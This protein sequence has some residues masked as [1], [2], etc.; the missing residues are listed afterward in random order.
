MGVISMRFRLQMA[1]LLG[2]AGLLAGIGALAQDAPPVSEL[3]QSVNQGHA[4]EALKK[5]AALRTQS[6]TLK[7]LSRVEGLA[8]F[9][10]GDL[11][12]ADEAFRMAIQEDPTDLEAVQMRGL[13]LFRRGRPADAIPLLEASKAKRDGKA[14][15]YYVLGLC[16]MDARRYDDSRHA[17]AAQYGFEPDSAPAYLVAARMMLRRESLP[18]A[19]QYAEK[20]LALEPT[21]PLAHE[22]LGEIA[23]AGNHLEEAITDFEAEKAHN[24]LEA[25]VYDRLGDAYVRAAKY[26]DAQLSLQQAVLLEPTATGPYILL[27]K[28]LLKKGDPLAAATYLERANGLDPANYMTHSLLAQAYR[29][30]GRKDDAT[31]ENEAAQKIQSASEP[32]FSDVK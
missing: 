10:Q 14:D 5:I 18:I 20:A 32:K 22:L 2:L 4:S 9:A 16:Y 6:S 1:F 24:P 30:M 23:L 7:G 11:R 15:P 29:S 26:D 3:R 13:V 19:K 8:Q 28:T 27:G 12:S 31:R 25:S 21:L 17:F